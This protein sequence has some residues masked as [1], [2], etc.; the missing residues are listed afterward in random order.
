M[1]YGQLLRIGRV[2]GIGLFG[3]TVPVVSPIYTGLYKS[4]FSNFPIEGP[5]FAKFIF[6]TNLEGPQIRLLSLLQ[7]HIESYMW[8]LQST[9]KTKLVINMIIKRN[10]K[11]KCIISIPAV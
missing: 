7:V 10:F 3:G 1:I 6:G 9:D 5:S 4:L 8:L 11:N 2:V